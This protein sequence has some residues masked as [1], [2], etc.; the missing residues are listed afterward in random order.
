MA[1]SQS[2]VGQ[3]VSHYRILKKLGGGGMG[4]VYKAED[5]RLKRH[6][7]LKFLPPSAEGNPAL[8][9]RFKREAEA[10]SALNHPNICTIH[11]FGQE[12]DEHFIVME[13]MDGRTLK[14]CIDEKPLPTEELLELGIQIADALDA[15]HSGGIVHRDIKPA[16]IF[17]TKRGQA[18]I[19]DFG[20]A[21][22]APVALGDESVG[23]PATPTLSGEELLTTPGTTLGTVAYMSP[24]QV[25]GEE[26]DNRTDLFS[27][28][29]V[30]YEMATGQLAFSG[31]TSG[32][33][34]EAILNRD[35]VAPS[36]INSQVPFALEEII[37]KSIE[38]D[39][40]LR[41][42]SA[43]EIRTD[44]Q[45]LKR[46]MVSG[47]GT[48]G[49][50]SASRVTGAAA[51]PAK[52]PVRPFR[53]K[54]IL[55]FGAFA[56]IASAVLALRHKFAE[57]VSAPHDPLSVLVADFT[58]D[59]GDSVFDG[60]LE[61]MLGVALEGAPFITGY[62]RDQA[63]R[64]AAQLQPGVTKLDEALA[65]LVAT[66]EGVNVVIAGS[67]A[68]A[69]GGYNIQERTIDA[70]TGKV[71]MES[72]VHAGNKDDVL[73]S[74]G[75]LSAQIR[76]AL[77]DTSPESVQLAAAETFTSTSLE[78]AQH[79]ARGQDLGWAG[80]DADAIR[81]YRDAARIDPSFGR[82]YAGLAVSYD[83]LGQHKESQDYYN[84]ALSHID[85]MSEREKYRTR[86]GYDLVVARDPDK[87]IEEFTSLVRLYP[88]DTA[89]IGMLAL[90]YFYKR[91]MAH[92]QLEG[93]RYIE[94]YPKNVPAKNNVGLY[95]MYASDFAAAIREQDSVLQLNPNFQKAYVGKALSQLGQGQTRDAIATWEKLK[96]IDQRGASLAAHGLADIALYQGRFKDALAILEPAIRADI[97]AGDNDGAGLKSALLVEAYVA[98]GEPAKAAAEAERALALTS[99]LG[100]K[101][102]AARAYIEA[103]QE[104]KALAMAEAMLN[105]LAADDHLYANI[106][107]GDAELKRG[108]AAPAIDRFRA[109]LNISDAWL[110]H[111][112]RARAYV[113]AGAYAQAD[114][115]LEL[116]LERRGEATAVY[117]D[118]NPSYHFLPPVY[119]YLG[120]AQEGLRSAAA[121]ESYKSFLSI[122]ESGDEKGLVADARRRLQSH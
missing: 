89:G 95:A 117:L 49:R 25:R 45:R 73:K 82:A 101:V 83:R 24:E 118:D 120:R 81:E 115:D 43:A 102:T 66:R 80:K 30:L 33:I 116:C 59:T 1:V 98:A 31:R 105:S 85:S 114:S 35:P 60:T 29:S 77:G 27:F 52:Q 69:A 8:I 121:A 47:L 54:W 2:F 74:L 72:A 109:A 38:R 3:T 19:L 55:A 22:L 57:P 79:Y 90:A 106:I 20:L 32:V 56:L 34:M 91:D 88:S 4:V 92:A 86:G 63:H 99:D 51:R 94:I 10:A 26:L 76:K 41:Y 68:R 61:P 5:T 15:A 58:N 93:R 9:E 64:V 62:K 50:L 97:K 75:K 65:R 46:E 107:Y 6:V 67:V 7:A 36:R 96:Q 53:L 87:A 13:F 113:A 37:V 103:G 23:S 84:L 39:R 104:Q 28:G 17:V 21:K 48:A 44:L 42:Q 12:G 108:H 111:L 78:A 71:I 122:K 11:D 40:K 14:R 16:N 70:V 18:K 110:A 100:V 119:Y 112:E